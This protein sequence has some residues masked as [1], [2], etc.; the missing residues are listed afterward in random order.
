V[1]DMDRAKKFYEAVFDLR[2]TELASP[3]I[4]M[5]AF[6]M[7]RKRPAPL[8]PWST[9]PASNPKWAAPSFTSTPPIAQSKPNARRKTAVGSI[10]QNSPSAITASFPSFTILKGT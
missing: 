5:L 6:P 1:Q 4:K 10:N 7:I 2:L 8:A 9:C 3:V